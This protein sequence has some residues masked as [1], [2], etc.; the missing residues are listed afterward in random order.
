MVM[1]ACVEAR[2]GEGKGDKLFMSAERERKEE[3]A[4]VTKPLFHPYFTF[5][6]RMQKS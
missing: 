2:K 6:R 1:V 4:S 3:G 5:A